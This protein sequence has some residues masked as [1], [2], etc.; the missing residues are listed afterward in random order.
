[1]IKEDLEGRTVVVEKKEETVTAK[2]EDHNR[3]LLEFTKQQKLLTER[4]EK[5]QGLEDR[6]AVVTDAWKTIDAM[7][8][9]LAES[10]ELDRERKEALTVEEVQ[11]KAEKEK[12]ARYLQK[13]QE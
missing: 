6:E 4:E 1:M 9:Q 10:Q 13:Y 3:N 11:L 12:I 5:I 2:I 8:L 7:K